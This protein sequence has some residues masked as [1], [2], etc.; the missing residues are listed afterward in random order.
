[1]SLTFYEARKV[2]VYSLA[3]VSLAREL[4]KA[5]SPLFIRLIRYT[6][7]G[8]FLDGVKAYSPFLSLSLAK[9]LT[10]KVALQRDTLRALQRDFTGVIW[11]TVVSLSSYFCL[12]NFMR[13]HVLPSLEYVIFRRI[14]T[15][16]ESM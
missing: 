6:V 9:Y 16:F 15:V 14:R 8:R 12:D 7:V 5:L 3:R 4:G 13:C 11:C 10:I 2:S 1:M